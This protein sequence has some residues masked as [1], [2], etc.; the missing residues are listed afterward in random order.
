MDFDARGIHTISFAVHP[1]H[2]ALKFSQLCHLHTENENSY[3]YRLM[4]MPTLQS[5][6]MIPAKSLE[7]ELTFSSLVTQLG[8]K[9]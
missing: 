9:Y 1:A 3:H 5:T 8:S 4:A 2:F 7:L 6:L